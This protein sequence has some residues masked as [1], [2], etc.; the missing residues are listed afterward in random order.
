MSVQLRASSVSLRLFVQCITH[1]IGAAR[2]HE[3]LG[4]AFQLTNLFPTRSALENVRL[5]VASR[6]RIGHVF[7]QMASARADIAAKAMAYLEQ[8]GMAHRS[9]S[10]VA[11]LSHGDQRKLEVALMLALEPEVFMFDEPTAGMSVD[12]S[13]GHTSELQSLM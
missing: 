8:V 13:E 1:R 7:W 6:H 10:P 9:D 4:L 3:G 12:R 2:A 11:N 5:A